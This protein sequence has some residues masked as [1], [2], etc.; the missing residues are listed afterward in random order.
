MINQ[1]KHT[2]TRILS[3]LLALMV[4]FS[5]AAP[6]NAYGESSGWAK[7]ELDEMDGLGLIPPSFQEMT[8]LKGNISRLEMCTIA[9][10]IFETYIG[11]EIVVSNPKPF[12]DTEDPIVAKAYAMGLTKGYED[13]SFRPYKLLTRQE[14]FMFIQQFLTSVG[15][16]PSSEHF[17]DLSQFADADELASWARDAASLVV[18]I[19]I[20]E[21]NEIG[22]TPERLTPREQGLVMFYRA[23]VFL[24]AQE[25]FTPSIPDVP[26]E[27]EIPFDEKYPNMSDWAKKELVPMEEQGLIPRI[28]IRRDMKTP[29]TRK[30]MCYVAVNAF[31]SAAPDTDISTG[32]SPFYDVDDST[33]TLAHKLGLVD[34]FPDNT[35]QPDNPITKEQFCKISANFLA[36][37]G[38]PE[39]DNPTVDLDRFQDVK[40][41]HN[42]ALPSTRLLVGLGIVKGSGEKLNPQSSTTC[43]EALAMFFRS[44]N[45][46]KGWEGSSE[47]PDARP[48]ADKLVDFAL[49]FEGYDYAW[50]G[51]SPST[52]FDCSG[53]VY[54]VFSHF[55][56]ELGRTAT[57]Q[58]FYED[59]VEVGLD[60]LLPGDLVFF[61]PSQ[62]VDD[63]T[64]VGIY[65]GD[66]QY[67]HAAN[68]ARGV[69]VDSTE[70]GYFERECLGA[71][72]IIH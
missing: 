20:V 41:L 12:T 69:V 8:S 7:K 35:F 66:A 54:Y 45:F 19:G 14:F 37:L 59:A 13:N 47:N 9:V 58:W 46:F 44:Y 62:D 36:V 61:S 48:L 51:S 22:L 39:T 4:V 56:F 15:W 71:K 1:K 65:V 70:T 52:G 32:E 43:Q 40:E 57:D 30:E 27:P 25:G 11:E 6:V 17:A 24:N 33:I 3:L 2:A 29:I 18:G 23:Y 34:G 63:I 31:L 53:L 28:L 5:L 72:R 60:E 50:G 21:G 67:L 38:Y 16:V 49:Q 64:H 10:H 42:Y 68:S 26:V 55:G